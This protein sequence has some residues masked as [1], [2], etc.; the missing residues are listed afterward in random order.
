MAI[1]KSVIN[2]KYEW[3]PKTTK[4]YINKIAIA[5]S[6][7]VANYWLDEFFPLRFTESAVARYGFTPRTPKYNRQKMKKYGHKKHL[8]YSGDM[9]RFFDTKPEEKFNKNKFSLIWSNVPKQVV[10]ANRIQTI[11][12]V[13]R[14]IIEYPKNNMYD[15]QKE[16]KANFD[17]D[18]SMGMI[19]TIRKGLGRQG[20][21][22]MP[23]IGRELLTFTN[24]ELKDLNKVAKKEYKRL[25]KL[26]DKEKKELFK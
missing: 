18:M 15:I 12:D 6:K 25:L 13:D 26:S 9:K 14:F 21:R 2:I 10:I 1:T 8:V 23:S 11:N 20:K 22:K 7:K 17:V 16:L 19:S 3:S 24:S 5:T 4:K